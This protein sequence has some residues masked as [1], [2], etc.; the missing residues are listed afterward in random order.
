MFYYC[1]THGVGGDMSEST[2]GVKFNQSTNYERLSKDQ[3]PQECPDWLTRYQFGAWQG[4]GLIVWNNDEKRIAR[5]NGGETFGLLKDLQTKE[6]WKNDGVSI[7]CHVIKFESELPWRGRRK[8]IEP[9]PARKESKTE[10]D[11]EEIVH[12]PPDA[13][14]RLIE[15]IQAKEKIISEMAKQEKVRFHKAI[16][17][18]L[19]HAEEW[20]H[21]KEQMDFD[22]STCTFKWELQRKNRWVCQNQQ[23]QG[24]VCLNS[25][26]SIWHA[27]WHACVERP[28]FDRKSEYIPQF[29]DAIAWTEKELTDLANQS[30]PP[31]PRTVAHRIEHIEAN[32]VKLREKYLDGPFWIRPAAM[33]PDRIAYHVFI[34]L[35]AEPISYKTYESICGGTYRINQHYLTP[36][37]QAVA[38][39]LDFDK[40]R[41]DQPLGEDSEW[42]QFT[43]LTAY[44][45]QAPA[46]EQ[47]LGIWDH[48]Q[49]LQQFKAGKINR[50]RYGYKEGGTGFVVVLGACEREEKPWEGTASREE[51]LEDRALRATLCYALDVNDFRDYLGLTLDETNDERLIETMHND[52]GKSIY[53]PA[54]VKLESKLWLARHEVI[55]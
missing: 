44:Y 47:A 22:F 43:S 17:D 1:A 35:E 53:M 46:A 26:M 21:E 4:E 29:S 3:K 40:F 48:S 24:H 32:H 25:T 54:E 13:G 34:E 37:K 30:E 7:T 11:I 8:K 39:G 41:I 31:E 42:Y 2:W 9:E 36:S 51:Y 18:L 14:L 38:I 28:G 6:D 50:G 45:Q 15:L 33:E 12:I 27:F 19:V 55:S 20:H 52:R 49:I 23:A 10:N 16:M 5:F